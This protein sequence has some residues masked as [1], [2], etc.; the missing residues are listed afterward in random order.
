MLRK[1]PTE[2]YPPREGDDSFDRQRRENFLLSMSESKKGFIRTKLD[3]DVSIRDSKRCYEHQEAAAV[4]L[5][6]VL[7]REGGA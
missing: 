3:D 7:D 6:E 1:K 4:A 5:L 2:V